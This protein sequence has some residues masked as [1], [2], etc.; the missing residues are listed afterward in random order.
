M[1]KL[2]VTFIL[3]CV[4]LSQKAESIIQVVPFHIEPGMTSDNMMTFNIEMTN[5]EDVWGVQFDLYLPK[6]M[7]LD[8]TDDYPPY[9]EI[10]SGAYSRYPYTSGRGGSKTYKHG[11][12]WNKLNDVDGHYWFAITPNDESFITETSGTILTLYCLTS[13]DMKPGVYP[14]IVRK[15]VISGKTVD[16]R[17]D[18]AISYVKVGDYSKNEVFNLGDDFYVPSFV[19]T[20]FEEDANIVV[21]GEC[22]NFVL[23]D[24]FTFTTPVAFTATKAEYNAVVGTSLGYRTLVLPYECSVPAGFE[25]YG[26][27]SVVNSELQMN[28][29]TTIPANTP[30]ILKNVGTAAMVAANVEIVPPLTELTGG[31]LV[32]TYEEID[33]PVGSYV[34]QN[35]SGNVAFYNVSEAVRPKVGAFRAYLAQQAA[36]PQHIRV[37]FNDTQ[38][39]INRLEEDDVNTQVYNLSGQCIGNAQRGV[40][41]IREGSKITKAIINK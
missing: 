9:D 25:A 19:E 1:N 37:N 30:V 8:Y 12:D 35:H 18:D 24:G 31:E 41:I 17:P 26:V 27:G 15:T 4:S 33:A 29:I 32:G 2:V 28:A 34:L 22:G 7:T 23:T 6:G 5:E 38:T 13:A 40:N 21:N 20:A 36:G 10:A 14:I 39:G 11:V 3:L 16:V